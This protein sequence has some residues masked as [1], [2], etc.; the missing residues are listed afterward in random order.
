V[1]TPAVRQLESS[2]AAVNTA[3]QGFIVGARARLQADPALRSEPRNLLEAMLVAADEAGSGI[4]DVQVAGNVL[5]MLLAGEDTTANTLA[6]MIDLLWRHP[7]SL[8]RATDEVR[9]VVADAAA[10]TMDELAR[11]DFIEACA[12]ETMRLKPVAPII[13]LQALRES[14]VGDVRLPAGGVILNVMRRDSVSDQHL[15]R[16]AAFEPERWLTTGAPG[17]AASVAKR[18]SM[19]FGAGP[20]IC[21]GRY[22]AL[23][24]MKMAMVA[25]LGHFDIESVATP[26]GKPA[27]EKMS[28]TMMPVGLALRL[29][30]RVAT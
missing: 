29:R 5:T 12:H 24:E 22:L 21:P 2:M 17:A 16:A 6:W 18:V 23:L 10:P 8:T 28:F 20:R 7:A 9:R 13:G 27:A 25:L 1:R 15:P 19:P 26:D 4:D 3:V 11:L 30:E 14:V